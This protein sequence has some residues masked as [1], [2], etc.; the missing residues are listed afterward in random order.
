MLPKPDMALEAGDLV[1]ISTT[2]DGMNAL[3]QQVC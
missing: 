2:P 3:R 1:H